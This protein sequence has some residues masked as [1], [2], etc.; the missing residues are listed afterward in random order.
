MININADVSITKENDRTII[1]IFSNDNMGLLI[2][3]NGKTLEAIQ[4]LISNFFNKNEGNER[5]IV[6]INSYRKQKEHKLVD[7][8]LKA[9]ADVKKKK[10]PRLL[11]PMNPFERR[12]IH[13]T[14]KEDREVETASEGE[15]N[16]RKIKISPTIINYNN[17]AE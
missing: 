16:F 1:N 13:M 10:R 8:A 17:E 7:L 6:D 15:G 4:T 9:A 11:E 12:I 2:G 14:L 5:I 3:K